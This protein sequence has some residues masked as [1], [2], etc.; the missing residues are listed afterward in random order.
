MKAVITGPRHRLT[1]EN[2]EFS[3]MHIELDLEELPKR[4]D[5]II[6]NSGSSYYVTNIMWWVDG[7]ENDAYWSQTGDYEVE[8]RYQVVHID[9]QPDDRR[10]YYGYPAGL[11]DGRK[12]GGEEFF[13]ELRNLIELAEAANITRDGAGMKVISA[14]L[15]VKERALAERRE[16][17][18][19][20]SEAAARIVAQLRAARDPQPHPDQEAGS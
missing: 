7:P 3:W 9:V 12:R 4:G 13:A 20:Q 17:E 15:A 19:Q 2:L 18:R 14:W 1:A 16:T 5:V 10:E 6:L 8:G 11:E